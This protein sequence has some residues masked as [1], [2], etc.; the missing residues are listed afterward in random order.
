MISSCEVIQYLLRCFYA[1]QS[2]KQASKIYN[3]RL[4]EQRN[5]HC[6][7]NERTKR[8][9]STDR[10]AAR[11][12][13]MKT[14]R[15]T[16]K[17]LEIF[18]LQHP[19]LPFNVFVL[20]SKQPLTRNMPSVN[21]SSHPHRLFTTLAITLLSAAVFVN[22]ARPTMPPS[23]KDFVGIRTEDGNG[24]A[25][26]N[27]S[28]ECIYYIVK[29]RRKQSHYNYLK[30]LLPPNEGRFGWIRAEDADGGTSGGDSKLMLLFPVLSDSRGA[31]LTFV[32][33]V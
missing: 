1:D 32:T 10:S 20:C 2:K 33:N 8:F 30:S 15:S 19:L 7:T 25:P 13:W 16:L 18:K 11:S 24:G 26:G 27:V 3:S 4:N 29:N 6:G 22:G 9:I 14:R 28:A 12:S 21:A 5:N 17:K 31:H 23:T